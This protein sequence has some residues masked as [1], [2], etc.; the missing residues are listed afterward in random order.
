MERSE[1]YIIVPYPLFYTGYDNDVGW[2]NIRVYFHLRCGIWRRTTGP[3]GKYYKEG[4]LVSRISCRKLAAQMKLSPGEVS[5]RIKALLMAKWI[6]IQGADKRG[7]P[8]TYILGNLKKDREGNILYEV[9]EDTGLK[10]PEELYFYEA[11]MNDV[12][13]KWE[14]GEQ[15][16]FKDSDVLTCIYDNDEA[17]ESKVDAVVSQDKLLPTGNAPLPTGNILLP[18]GN[19]PLPTGN[20]PLPTGNIPLPSRNTI[21][22]NKPMQGK[23]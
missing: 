23:K 7:M 12:V 14:N 19:A 15:Q 22:N 2:D 10:R 18:T 8:Y 13:E 4:Y 21:D 11:E 9:N 6:A 16:K 3:L 20:A 1:L 17:E 5:K